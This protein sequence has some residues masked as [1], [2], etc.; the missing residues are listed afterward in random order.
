MNNPAG[1]HLSSGEFARRAVLVAG[2]ALLAFAF[3]TFTW[4]VSQGL[5][6]IFA[7][8][9]LAVMLN[10]MADILSRRTRLRRRWALAVTISVLGLLIIG[11]FMLGGTRMVAEAPQLQK[12]LNQSFSQITH[13]LQGIGINLKTLGLDKGN[14]SPLAS[15]ATLFEHMNGYISTSIQL[16]TDLLV[17][18]IAGVYFAA[19]PG[20]YIE[21]A[22]LL[23]PPAR[24]QRLREVAQEVGHALWRWLLGR[25][26]SMLAVGILAMLGLTLL[27]VDLAL[28]LGFIAGMLTFI[29][30]LGTIISLVP[31]VL[32]GLLQSPMTAVY[33]LLL[34][35]GAHFLEGYVLTP[36]IQERTVHL[37]PGW[38]I[39]AQLLGELAAGIFGIIIAAPVMV[40]VTI[41]VQMLYIEDVLG[42]KVRILG[43]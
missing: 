4:T 7:A 31:A 32:M 17:I 6:V 23:C 19:S 28:L 39:V 41:A 42:D 25:F 15:G 1:P 24:R 20:L 18:L 5:L 26:A 29:P 8:I 3:A 10:G 33:V 37:A 38:L 40:V 2:V 27:G 22:A 34:F 13:Q 30:Y 36:L 43:E 11:V 16:L 21:T 12:G 9:L 35:L 14:L